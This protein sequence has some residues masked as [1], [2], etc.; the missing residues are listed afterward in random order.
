MQ[1]TT[2]FVTGLDGFYLTGLPLTTV[3]AGNTWRIYG[4]NSTNN[5]VRLGYGSGN[6]AVGN[7]VAAAARTIR[8]GAGGS[9]LDQVNTASDGAPRRS[10]SS[11]PSRPPGR[12]SLPALAWSA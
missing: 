12:C 11:A 1:S 3:D 8:G 7:A 6:S 5:F 9:L 4:I 10:R 2:F